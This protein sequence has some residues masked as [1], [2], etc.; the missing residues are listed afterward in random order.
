MPFA[1]SMNILAQWRQEIAGV[2]PEGFL[3]IS[4]E[5][6]FL[7]VSDFPKRAGDA[8][9][10]CEALWKKGFRTEIRGGLAYMDGNADVYARADAALPPVMPREST[11]NRRL[12]FIA[13][14]LGQGQEDFTL[15]RYVLRCLGLKDENGLMKL[16]GII[17]LRKR[18]KQPLS[19]LAGKILLHA[20]QEKEDQAC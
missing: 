17:A 10:V 1:E 18:K 2:L 14:L 4:R 5:E 20:I 7:F 12:L 16:P 15:A 19:P 9:S 6:E 3:R 13:R 8:Q 11:E